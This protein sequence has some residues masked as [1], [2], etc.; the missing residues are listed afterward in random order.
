M[1]EKTQDGSATQG[2]INI[3]KPMVSRND[4]EIILY[5]AKSL[6]E[7]RRIPSLMR[8][9]GGQATIRRNRARSPLAARRQI[10]DNPVKI[11]R[12]LQ[13]GQIF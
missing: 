6:V 11:A 7:G 8:N 13:P 12:P 9:S 4:P 3:G 1:S 5:P 10:R 2:P